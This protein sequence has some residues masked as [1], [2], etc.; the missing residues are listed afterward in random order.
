LPSPSGKQRQQN[1]ETTP[2]VAA[3]N[4]LISLDS[5]RET[6][7]NT[8]TTREGA[9]RRNSA[10]RRFHAAASCHRGGAVA[11]FRER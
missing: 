9:S 7:V 4:A 6:M 11:F 5:N 1:P 10:L 8:T 2:R 3:A